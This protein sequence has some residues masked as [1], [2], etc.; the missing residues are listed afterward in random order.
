MKKS[1]MRLFSVLMILFI[2]FIYAAPAVHAQ[3]KVINERVI[4]DK[5]GKILV[6]GGSVEF[7]SLASVLLSGSA[8]TPASFGS[9]SI[10]T[11]VAAH[12]FPLVQRTVLTLTDVPLVTAGNAGGSETNAWGSVKVYDF[13]EGRILVHGVMANGIAVTPDT[14]A[15]PTGGNGNISLGSVSAS[16]NDLASTMVNLLPATA[17]DNI[18]AT[19]A[20]NNALAASAQLDGTSTAVDLYV[21]LGVDDDNWLIGAASGTNTVSGTITVIWSNLGD[22]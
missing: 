21:N 14:N 13:P 4:V 22:Y 8:V 19:N 9:A 16:T 2:G 7:D 17:L 12:S 6:N 1:K 11:A 20:V 10:A 15:I 3:G 5:G 18:S